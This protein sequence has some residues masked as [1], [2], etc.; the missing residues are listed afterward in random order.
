MQGPPGSSGPGW[1][2]LIRCHGSGECS[3]PESQW[4]DAKSP[5]SPREQSPGC[6]TFTCQEGPRN[7]YLPGRRH[8]LKRT[9]GPLPWVKTVPGP[10]WRCSNGSGWVVPSDHK[11]WTKSSLSTL[12]PSNSWRADHEEPGS[13]QEARVTGGAGPEGGAGSQSYECVTVTKSQEPRN[14]RER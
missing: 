8:L 9:W 14:A 4:Q 2:S 6:R 12:L 7:E 3:E 10:G 11:S 5:A 1:V 13:C